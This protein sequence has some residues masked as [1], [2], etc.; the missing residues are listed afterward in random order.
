MPESPRYEM[1]HGHE[2]TA[3]RTMAKFYGV[4]THHE[5]INLEVTEIKVALAAASGD[6][7]WYEVFTAPRMLYRVL[8]AISLQSFQ[9]LTGA[10][11]FFYYGTTVFAGVGI[12]NSFITAMIL[13]AVNF[14][15]TFL[16]L[17]MVEKF[18]RRKCLISGALCMF[19]CFII[20][21]SVGHFY[22][23]PAVEGSSQAQTGGGIMIAFSCIFIVAYASTW[24][25]MV[26]T[27]ISEMFPYRY[28]AGGMSYAT[29]ANWFWN[30]MIAFFTSFITGDIDFMYGYV[31]AGCNLA[32]AVVVYFFLMESAGRTI[33]EV[34]SMY[35][36]HVPVTKSAKYDIKSGG[37]LIKTDTL[38]LDR[39]GRGIT[40]R[41]AEHV[42]GGVLQPSQQRQETVV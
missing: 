22:F 32:A 39:G 27:C 14:G 24:G 40:K 5:L 8:L 41:N 31:F 29:A 7:P 28:R 26:W 4:S 21:A 6:H 1:R 10:N 42:E 35:L 36:M 19:V 11:Y 17:Y 37:D 15:S 34:D 9:Q 23:E 2:A 30:F 13:G 20:F 25:P 33:E 16:G 3:T 38:E 18:G 12:S